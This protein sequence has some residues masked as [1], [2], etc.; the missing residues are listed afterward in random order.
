L[1]R[2]ELSAKMKL[3]ENDYS[4]LDISSEEELIKTFL[5]PAAKQQQQCDSPLFWVELGCGAAGVAKSIAKA[6]SADTLR[7][8]GFEVDK[9]QL[10]KNVAENN[11]NACNN[12]SFE[13]GGMQD[14]ALADGS[15]DAVI[16]LKSLHHVPA[17]LLEGGFDEVYRILKPGGKLF[18]SEPVFAGEFNDILRIFHDEQA[19]RANAFEQLQKQV[20]RGRFQLEQEI[21]F[22]SCSKYPKGF[23]DFDERIIQSTHTEHKLEEDKLKMVQEK[24]AKHVQEDGS[25]HFLIPMR[26]DVLVRS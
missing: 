14:I 22:T 17:E 9:I 13:Y 7:I 11:N 10:E 6:F 8:K 12:L 15:V 3:M 5:L 25:A 16:M 21:H 1:K 18:V 20:T 26:V 4:T 2:I 19:V 23:E 24:F